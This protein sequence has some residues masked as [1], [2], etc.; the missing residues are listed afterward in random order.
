MQSRGAERL[1][2]LAG[3][4]F[5]VLIIV[6]VA[7]GGETP[8]NDDSPQKI[9]QFWRDHD[10]EQI[11]TSVIVA[12]SLVFFVWFA[13]SVRAVLRRAEGGVGRLSAVSFGG[14]LIGATG[15]LILASL[16]FAAADA[17]EDAPGAVYTITILNN[18]VFFP[19][20]VG[21]G[22][23]YLATG[24]A[25]LRFGVL[26]AWAAWVTIVLGILHVTPIGFFALL[27]GLIWILVVSIV[28]YRRE[29]VTADR[30]R[31]HRPHR[32]CSETAPPRGS[33]GTGANCRFPAYLAERLRRPPADASA[34]RSSPQCELPSSKEGGGA[35]G[36]K[37]S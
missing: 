2:P 25:A 22:V 13:G 16:N 8:S 17:I 21:L 34:A 6:A 37:R 7:I 23:F 5:V 18:E 9:L 3:V 29:G 11:W 36:G 28:L 15:L 35:P 31:P 10:T 19:I 33:W 30:H 24:L 12:W 27:A 1:A 14:A 20:A 26:P 32:P 4:V